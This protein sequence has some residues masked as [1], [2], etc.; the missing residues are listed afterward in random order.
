MS[1][2]QTTL[3]TLLVAAVPGVLIALLAHQ[4]DL[5]R[6]AQAER[7]LSQNARTL[8][9]LEL[10]ANRAILTTFWTTINGLDRPD[11]RQNAHGHLA[12][13]AENGLLS[14]TLPTWGFTRWENLSPKSLAS[15]TSSD[16]KTIDA[17]YRSLHAITDMYAK[18]VTITPDEMAQ[19]NKDR[20][21]AN[22]FADW[23]NDLFTRLTAEVERVLHANNP[24]Q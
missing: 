5:R 17:M 15:L 12:G 3:L 14:Y 7:R 11:A 20:F 22:R 24:L 9:G 19:L 6:D 16:L 2:V 4:L 13:M 10:D 21:W 18:I 1:A 8:L 23:R